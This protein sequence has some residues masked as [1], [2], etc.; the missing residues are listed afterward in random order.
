MPRRVPGAGPKNSPLARRNRRNEWSRHFAPARTRF[1]RAAAQ[2]HPLCLA[3]RRGPS[4]LTGIYGNRHLDGRVCTDMPI[5][6][7]RV[8]TRARI[9]AE[10]APISPRAHTARLRYFSFPYRKGIEAVIASAYREHMRA[11]YA[12]GRSPVAR[13]RSAIQASISLWGQR[14]AR[15]PIRIGSGNWPERINR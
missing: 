4:A 3:K 15:G 8:L 7:G 9:F 12:A 5:R 14:T 10:N 1:P 13:G 2:Q 11:R 6:K